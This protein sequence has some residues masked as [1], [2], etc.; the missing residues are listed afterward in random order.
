MA[1]AL[2]DTNR[3][4]VVRFRRDGALT[5]CWPSLAPVRGFVDRFFRSLAAADPRALAPLLA[6]DCRFMPQDWDHAEA[7]RNIRGIDAF[8]DVSLHDVTAV[9]DILTVELRCRW[10]PRAVLR[11]AEG[12]DN[13]AIRL[14]LRRRASGLNVVRLL[15]S[16]RSDL[17]RVVDGTYR[18]QLLEASLSPPAGTVLERTVD[19]L[20]ELQVE[21]RPVGARDV[22][23]NIL[24]CLGSATD[25]ARAVRMRLIASREAGGRGERVA[26]SQVEHLGPA[27][28]RRL[29]GARERWLFRTRDGTGWRSERWTFVRLGNRHFLIKAVATGA[30]RSEAQRALVAAEPWY[31]TVTDALRID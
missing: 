18:H 4:A 20:V 24:G 12:A 22:W 1:A 15:P 9:G 6:P 29:A 19:G 5:T 8:S 31:R 25:S 21:L 16:T 3:V 28:G 11:F 17:G 13:W 7:L 2:A 27:G 30:T 23:L 10:Q 26:E 14:L